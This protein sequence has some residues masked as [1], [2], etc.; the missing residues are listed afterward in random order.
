MAEDL[1]VNNGDNVGRKRPVGGAG[2]AGARQNMRSAPPSSAAAMINRIWP[3]FAVCRYSAALCI[4]DQNERPIS[5]TH[6]R[7]PGKDRLQICYKGVQAECSKGK[8]AASDN[9][10][11]GISK[12]KRSSSGNRGRQPTKFAPVCRLFDHRSLLLHEERQQP[13]RCAAPYYLN[14]MAFCAPILRLKCATARACQG[15]Q[16]VYQPGARLPDEPVG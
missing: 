12:R 2:H 8:P 6:R 5:S 16:V 3:D 9:A 11:Q 1:P 15:I 13:A 10:T 7:R 4:P 14:H